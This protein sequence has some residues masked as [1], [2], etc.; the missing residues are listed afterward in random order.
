MF[1]TENYETSG[2]RASF[3]DSDN[4]KFNLNSVSDSLKASQKLL[5]TSAEGSVYACTLLNG[6]TIKLLQSL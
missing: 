3:F 5:L 2:T 1:M 4:D 6:E